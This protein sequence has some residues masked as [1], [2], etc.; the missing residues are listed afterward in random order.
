[1]KNKVLL[2]TTIVFFLLINTSYYWETKTGAFAIPVF[3]LIL[4]V[5]MILAV[6]LLRQVSF[7]V[8]ERFRKKWR[9]PLIGLLASVLLLS[10]F[11]PQGI[12]DFE[13]FEAQDILIAEREGAANCFTRLKLKEDLSFKENAFCFGASET[14]GTYRVAHDTIYFENIKS[15]RNKQNPYRFAIIRPSLFGNEKILNDLVLYRNETDSSGYI[16]RITKN[17]L[18]TVK[19]KT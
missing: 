5:Y 9:L 10:F 12:V 19:Q 18:L 17:E 3:F 6:A 13:K 16:L 14:R 1:M 15:S 2:T 4:T 7:A 11:Y 8:R